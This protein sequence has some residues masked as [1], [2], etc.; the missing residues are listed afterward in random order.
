M[1]DMVFVDKFIFSNID[2][3]S[4]FFPSLSELVSSIVFVY[5][6]WIIHI[7]RWITILC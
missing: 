3:I 5:D 2:Y 4:L 7:F 1:N 6:F